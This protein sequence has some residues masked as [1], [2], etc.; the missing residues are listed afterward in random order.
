MTNNF[1][2]LISQITTRKSTRKQKTKKLC[3]T[4]NKTKI[5]IM[6]SQKIGKC[7]ALAKNMQQLAE[8][9]HLLLC[10]NTVCVY[11]CPVNRKLLPN[12]FH[13]PIVTPRIQFHV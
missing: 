8:S 11:K 10:P 7:P 3:Y 6:S 5:Y 13:E 9:L 1:N 4:E 2:Y 12:A